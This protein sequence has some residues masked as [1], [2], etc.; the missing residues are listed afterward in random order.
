MEQKELTLREI[1]LGSLNVLLK[2]KD[3]C[4]KHNIRYYLGYGTLIGAIRHKGFIPWDDDID[5]LMPREDYER[6]INLYLSNPEEFEP[7]ELLHYKTN[8]KYIY[9][10]ARLSDPAYKIDYDNAKEYGLG[11]FV[12][13]YPLDGKDLNDKRHLRRMSHF[14][15]I[16][17]VGGHKHLRKARNFLRNIPKFIFFIYTRFRSLNKLIAKSDRIAQKYDFFKMEYGCCLVTGYDTIMKSE[18]FKE[19]VE[20]DFEGYKFACPAKYDEHLKEIYG[21]YMQLPPKEEC[22]AHHYYKAYKK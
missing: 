17:Y 6:L 4:V 7:F 18:H 5:I 13:I 16:I 19:S 14:N 20:L 21:D 10:L 12:D 11:L 9:S 1:Q 15:S 2:L 8:K 22:V 3:I